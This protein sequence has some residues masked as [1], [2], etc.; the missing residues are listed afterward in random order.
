MAYRVLSLKPVSI[1]CFLRR[2]VEV[3]RF[4]KE[5]SVG[6]FMSRIA[7]QEA[8]GG[9]KDSG[10]VNGSAVGSPEEAMMGRM[11]ILVVCR[12]ERLLVEEQALVTAR[13]VVYSRHTYYKFRNSMV[14]MV[15][16]NLTPASSRKRMHKV[17]PKQAVTFV[18]RTAAHALVALC[19]E[20]CMEALEKAIEFVSCT[21]DIHAVMF[22]HHY[23][24]TMHEM[25]HTMLRNGSLGAGGSQTEGEGEGDTN[26]RTRE[27]SNTKE[28]D[29]S[30]K[31]GTRHRTSSSAIEKSSGR[32][33]S[34]QGGSEGRVQVR[35]KRAQESS[36]GRQRVSKEPSAERPG[37][38]QG[39]VMA[40]DRS[41]ALLPEESE[42]RMSEV[43]SIASVVATGAQTQALGI[44]I[45]RLKTLLKEPHARLC[46]AG[47]FCPT[48]QDVFPSPRRQ[49]ADDDYADSL[50]K[51]SASMSPRSPKNTFSGSGGESDFFEEPIETGGTDMIV[52]ETLSWLAG[53]NNNDEGGKDDKNGEDG[54]NI[55]GGNPARPVGNVSRTHSNLNEEEDLRCRS[56]SSSK[57]YPDLPS[58]GRRSGALTS[59]GWE[60]AHLL[61]VCLG[62][63]LQPGGP[64]P[65]VR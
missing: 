39:G 62:R 3:V 2:C 45:A 6:I 30:R 54:H 7:V 52:D 8:G 21:S 19:Y 9:G 50:L 28:T 24:S 32:I 37:T 20:D 43:G 64:S 26:A 36:S 23:I 25:G 14:H 33:G 27:T 18:C 53:G 10:T 11:G 40:G 56:L 1:Y 31:R 59:T 63:Y 5:N 34:T 22:V 49:A 57:P 12:F 55:A 65:G 47:Q 58:D 44:R 13:F 16:Y 48:L 38:G 35:I 29:S 42:R 4:I 51:H 46:S 60:V 15:L 61:H 17:D 41:F